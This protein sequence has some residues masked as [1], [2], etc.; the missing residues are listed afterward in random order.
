MP[1]NCEVFNCGSNAK[2]DKRKFFRI[3]AI[4]TSGKAET[5]RLSEVR[6]QKWIR[7]ISR[8]GFVPREWSRVCE[9][10]FISGKFCFLS[11][12]NVAFFLN[13]KFRALF[14]MHTC[15]ASS[16]FIMSDTRHMFLLL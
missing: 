5:I 10:H 11:Y 6:R 14:I 3:P 4:R 15:Y 8:E 2:R 16:F 12:I 9:L 7:A 1:A 13:Y